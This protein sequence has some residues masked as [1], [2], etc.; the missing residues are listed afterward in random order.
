MRTL[1]DGD[2]EYLAKVYISLIV[3]IFITYFTIVHV[4]SNVG[5]LKEN[6]LMIALLLMI[7]SMFMMIVSIFQYV[8][9][10]LMGI[11]KILMY[12]GYIFLLYIIL[13]RTTLTTDELFDIIM[14]VAMILVGMIGISYIM[15]FHLSKD[16]FNMF[17]RMIFGLMMILL[18]V[19]LYNIIMSVI[20]RSK[21]GREDERYKT[22]KWVLYLSVTVFSLMILYDSWNIL[23]KENRTENP[24]MASL[25]LWTDI[26]IIFIDLIRLAE[27]E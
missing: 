3:Q 11:V 6:A 9:P 27:G 19:L 15:F 13:E 1:T 16:Y 2:Y 8:N 12:I 20:N 21:A 23:Y 10:M 17:T 22:P 26:V 5:V 18:V 24:F 4:I 14:Q 7:G 25:D